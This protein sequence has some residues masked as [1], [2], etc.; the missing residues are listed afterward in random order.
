MNLVNTFIDYSYLFVIV[1]SHIAADFPSLIF[2]RQK[3]N[4]WKNISISNSFSYFS[5]VCHFPS[6][7]SLLSHS[8]S[9]H[10]VF[11]SFH[12]TSSFFSNLFALPLSISPCQSPTREDK[13]V[14]THFARITL[15]TLYFSRLVSAHFRSRNTSTSLILT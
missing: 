8:S 2:H 7:I 11:F 1:C 9:L 6:N 4:E 14:R 13:H 10:S 5:C 12:L 15:F 3:S